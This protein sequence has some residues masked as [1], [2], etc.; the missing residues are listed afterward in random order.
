M[1]TT[2]F[3]AVGENIHCTRIYKVGGKFVHALD[4]DTYGITYTVDG[5]ERHLPIPQH[6]VESEE[7]AKKKVKHVAVAIWQGVYGDAAGKAAGIDYLEHM[8]RVQEAHGASFLDLNVDEFSTDVDE[9][10]QLIQ[11]AAQV[12]QNVSSVPLSI[13]SSDL[14][15]LKAGLAACDPSKGKP[16][17]NSIS[18]ERSAAINVAAEA[19]AVVIA[20]ATGETSMPS[21][22]EDRLENFDC[23]LPKLTEAGFAYEDIYLDPLVF[24]ASVDVQNSR[25]V[26][27]V[28][29]VLREKYGPDIHFAPGLSNVSYGLPKRTW[30]NVV[31][32]Y[33]CHQQGCDGGIVDPR[34]IN[35]NVLATIDTTSEAFNVAKALLM[36]KDQ[37]GMDYILAVRQG[38]I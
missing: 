18:L 33:L 12:I 9:R 7:W 15:I 27:D 25:R 16:M 13:D 24:P 8:V 21:T 5:E 35:T 36:G 11:W 10:V 26:I 34:H 30:L 37:Y 6:F 38:V 28:I 4:D 32:T 29:K 3:I 23:L 31:F 14:A 17:V 19:G 22:L 1:N 20:G 2:K